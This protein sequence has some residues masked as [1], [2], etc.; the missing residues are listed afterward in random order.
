M[1]QVLEAPRPTAAERRAQRNGQGN[2]NDAQ[3]KI[4]EPARTVPRPGRISWSRIATHVV[5][6]LGAAMMVFPFYW[7]LS[8]SLKSNQEALQSPPTFLPTSLHPENYASALAAAPFGRY[9]LNTSFVATCQVVGVLAVSTLAAYAFARMDFYGKDMV[10][11]IFLST[12]MIPSEVTLIP[13]FIIITKWLGWYNTYQAQIVPTL[14]SVFAIFLLRQFFKSIPTEL[15]EASKLDGCG[16]LRF[17]WSVVL[18][19]STPAV[20]TVALFNFLGAWN[21]FLWPLIVTRSPD[22]RPIQLGL[23][24]FTTENSSAY[25]QLMAASTLVIAPTVVL[26]LVAQRY[27]IEGIARSGLKG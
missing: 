9:F 13:N 21:A 20:I 26:F 3:R 17:L 19:L 23:Q 22:M 8:T 2:L 24:V 6:L 4:N 11:L 27:F 7:M 1:A 25:G 15:E 5:L 18:P 12:L 14:G 16:Q 10:F